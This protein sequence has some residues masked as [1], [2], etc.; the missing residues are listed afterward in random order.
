MDDQLK[1]NE[2]R[3]LQYLKYLHI[4]VRLDNSQ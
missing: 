1:H 3:L 4:P 2:K